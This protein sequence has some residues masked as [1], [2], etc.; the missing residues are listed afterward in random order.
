MA[1]KTKA[2]IDFEVNT[3]QFNNSIKEMNSDIKTLTNQL[4][5]N[6]TQLK[7]NSDDVDLLKE[8]QSLLSIELQKSVQ[9]IDDTNKMLEQAKLQFGDY[10]LK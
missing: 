1:G 4:R 7:G 10:L 8:R 3:S 5:L 2:Q 6:A 9:K